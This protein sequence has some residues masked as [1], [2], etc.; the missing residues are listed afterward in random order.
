MGRGRP[1]SAIKSETT[2]RE[3]GDACA[4][5]LRWFR[6]LRLK[7]LGIFLLS[8]ADGILNITNYFEEVVNGL[9]RQI[10][11]QSL[12]LIMDTEVA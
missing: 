9:K 7:G 5:A 8:I 11:W 1:V 4:E 10:L 6:I 3:A 12:T 2:E